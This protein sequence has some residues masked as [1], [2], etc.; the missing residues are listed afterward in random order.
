MPTLRKFAFAFASGCIGALAYGIFLWLLA[1]LGIAGALGV[2]LDVPADL[3]GMVQWLYSRIVWGGIWGFLFVAPILPE[4]WLKRGFLISLAPALAMLF[5][6]LPWHSPA[7]FLGLNAGLLTPV[8][9]LAA[10]AVWGVVAAACYE[11]FSE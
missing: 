9:L 5:I 7:G 10:H 11:E 4:E 6:F 1:G 8:I 2:T 3:D